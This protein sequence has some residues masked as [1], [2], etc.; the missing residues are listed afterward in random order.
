MTLTFPGGVLITGSN[1][2]LGSHIVSSFIQAGFTNIACHYRTSSDIVSKVLSSNGLNPQTHLFRAE[3]T[4]E[5]EVSQL[6]ECIERQMGPVWGI[7]NLAGGSSN[8]IS[9]KLSLKDF[10][11]VLA[12]NLTSTFLVVREFLPALRERQGGRI[13]NISSVAAHTPVAGTSHYCAAKSA[14]EGFTRG[15]A[16]E[17]APKKITVNCIALGYC[18]QGIIAHI[19]PN[20]LEAIKSRITVQRLGTPSELF[21]LLTYLMSPSAEFM[22]GQVLHLNGGQYS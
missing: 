20:V 16:V 1:G 3:L 22:T 19:P 15:V 8:S 18:D 21:A 5:L 10:N 2:G 17:A 7:V 13:V 11:R 14:I 9:W 6:R 4:S 12:D